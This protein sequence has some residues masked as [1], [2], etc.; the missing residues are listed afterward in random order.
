MK[1][2][3]VDAVS[4][5]VAA[6]GLIFLCGWIAGGIPMAVW[7]STLCGAPIVL[8]TALAGGLIWLDRR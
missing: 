1:N 5:S 8:G 3:L 2:Y 4:P 6:I 7:A